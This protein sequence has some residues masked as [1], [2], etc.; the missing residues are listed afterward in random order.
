MGEGGRLRSGGHVGA[1]QPQVKQTEVGR[2]LFLE[3]L[4]SYLGGE[5]REGLE[6][7]YARETMEAK[8]VVV[9]D[10][11]GPKKLNNAQFAELKTKV[12][13]GQAKFITVCDF[14]VSTVKELQH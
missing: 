5:I 13:K 1:S 14:D 9:A 11:R 7:M 4:Q 12:S 3:G 2:S 6:N 10:S 8:Q